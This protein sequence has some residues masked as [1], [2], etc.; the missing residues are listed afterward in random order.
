MQSLNSHKRITERDH[1][2]ADPYPS[3][4]GPQSILWMSHYIG[5]NGKFYVLCW[6]ELKRAG[7][8]V[9]GRGVREV[10]FIKKYLKLYWTERQ[11]TFKKRNKFDA[12]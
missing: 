12:Y 3:L 2:I 11:Q 10:W 9:V 7:M 6:N 1:D 4:E 5:S 8:G